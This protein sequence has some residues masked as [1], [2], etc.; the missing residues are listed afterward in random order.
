M[1]VSTTKKQTN[2]FQP[3]QSGNPDGRPKGARNKA[4][5]M[6]EKLMADDAEA[7]TR[8]IINKAKDGDMQAARIIMDRIAPPRKGRTI[9]LE[10]PDMK[11]ATGVAEAQA[12]V[13]Q[14][15]GDGIVSPDEGKVLADI[16]EARRKAIETVDHEKRLAVLERARNA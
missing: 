2:R 10:L 9:E 12:A 8:A 3:G 13:L 4:T 6:A 7:V 11:N 5:V 16:I 15:V 14:A 1:P